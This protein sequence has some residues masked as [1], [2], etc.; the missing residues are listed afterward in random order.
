MPSLTS[1]LRF[2]PLRLLFA[3]AGLLILLLLATNAA[4]ILHLRATELHD[5]ENRLE[6]LSL[7][8]AEQAGRA[9]QSVDL[10]ISSIAHGMVA[11]RVTDEASFVREMAGHNVHSILQ[12]KVSGLAQLNAVA[13]MSRDGKLINTSREWPIPEIDVTDR[14]YFRALTENPGLDSYLSEP[15]RNRATGTWTIFLALKVRG[16]NGDFLGIVIGAIEMNYFEDFYHAILLGEGST[17]SLQRADGVM[18]A[19]F[20]RTDAIGKTFS[21]SQRLL[22]GGVSGILREFSPIDGQMRL[23]AA[24]L[25]PDYSVVTV[26][27]KTQEAALAHWRSVAR[28]MTLGALGCAVSIAFAA[29]AFGRQ[30]KQQVV[31]DRSQADLRRQEDRTAAMTIAKEAAETADRAKSEFLANMSHE[32]RTPM[33]GI[34]GMNG[35]LLDTKLDND[36][37]QYAEMVRVSATSL[38][39]ILND[40]L[41]V[42]KLEAGQVGIERIEFDIAAMVDDVMKLFVPQARE[43]DLKLSALVAPAVSRCYIGDPTRLR[44]ILVNLVGNA[45]KFTE[46]GGIAVEIR[47]DAPTASGDDLVVFEVS[48]TGIGIPEEIRSRLFQKFSQADG[49]I[50]RRFGG[51]GLGLSISKQLTELMGGEIGILSQPGQGSKF[52]FTVPLAP[53]DGVSLRRPEGQALAPPPVAEAAALGERHI[54]LVDDNAV[55]RKIA[56]IMLSQAGYTV[57]VATDGREAVEAVCRNDFDLVLMDVQMPVMDGIEAT[58]RIR[59]LAGVAARVPIVAMTAHALD[60]CRERCMAV[61]MD[62]YL[63]KPFARDDLLAVVR[64][65]SGGHPIAKPESPAPVAAVSAAVLIDEVALTALAD[66]VAVA[67]PGLIDAYLVGSAQMVASIETATAGADFT[68]LTKVA[69]DLIA[70]AGNF[71]AREL[72][73]LATRLER[74]S[75]AGAEAEALALAAE[76]GPAASRTATA[77]SIWLATRAA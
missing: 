46:R 55:N 74:A 73:S 58:Q 51:T 17:V 75:R 18:L 5:E 39:T 40:V 45:V 64:R 4:V 15:V 57:A 38:L 63:T 34:I 47:C 26:A 72:Q 65:W 19:R 11:A 43:K 7:I 69:H 16:A 25:V 61:G 27:T 49:S 42:S 24:H 12:E 32:L 33:N 71:G 62:D 48:D 66:S 37:Q 76:V 3:G 31:L 67:L 10:A 20:P 54:L 22:S 59:Q 29:A 2:A 30:W 9:F 56:T 70:T 14:D 28:L 36:Q 50:A 77:M 21:D 41:D 13:V 52:W 60:D 35:L 68:A 44:Q 23:K 53:T 8:M 6:N 1:N